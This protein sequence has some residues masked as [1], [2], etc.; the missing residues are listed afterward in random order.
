MTSEPSAT[1]ALQNSTSGGA[2]VHDGNS[3]G[4]LLPLRGPVW[5]ADVDM[6][7]DAAPSS[8][9]FFRVVDTKRLGD[10]HTI[11]C[12]GHKLSNTDLAIVP[13]RIVLSMIDGSHVV[14]VTPATRGCQTNSHDAGVGCSVAAATPEGSSTPVLILTDIEDASQHLGPQIDARQ[15]TS[16]FQVWHVSNAGVMY[17]IRDFAPESGDHESLSEVLAALLS[18]GAC[19]TLH[20]NRRQPFCIPAAQRSNHRM[21]RVFAAL[22]FAGYVTEI[23]SRSKGPASASHGPTSAYYLLTELGMQSLVLG[24]KLQK[25]K[26][27]MSIRPAVTLANMTALELALRAAELGWQW[28][29][30]PTSTAQR[31]NVRPYKVGDEQVW[32]THGLTINQPYLQCLMSAG[33]LQEQFSIACIPHG[34]RASIYEAMLQGKRQQLRAS[35]FA[36]VEDGECLQLAQDE[37]LNRKRKHKQTAAIRGLADKASMHGGTNDPTCLAPLADSDMTEAPGHDHIDSSGED[38]DA[39]ETQLGAMAAGSDF[40]GSAEVETG[41]AAADDVGDDDE[42]HDG[43]MLSVLTHPRRANLRRTQWGI[44]RVTPKHPGSAN[45]YGGWEATCP[46]HRRNDLTGCKKYIAVP[47]AAD[48][49]R[50]AALRAV[51]FWCSRAASFDRQWKHLGFHPTVSDAPP[52]PVLESLPERRLPRPAAPK[53]DAELDGALAPKAKARLKRPKLAAPSMAPA[54]SAQNPPAGSSSS[55][56]SNSSSRSSSSDPAASS[57]SSSSSS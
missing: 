30:L 56:G 14:D 10:I 23:H 29:R 55:S 11:S 13:H 18:T 19:E 22:V 2:L 47:S 20:E 40:A 45:K 52:W 44:F 16:S 42:H 46:Y 35:N 4:A 21:Q 53:T 41:G 49:A 39:V 48:G 34:Q 57:S 36:L 27:V 50:D 9:L 12:A 31:R 54:A 51:I 28:R 43:Q 25:P 15:L 7:D 24:H 5:T 32:F 37:S 8:R 6:Q 3:G 38:S 33:Q 17:T 26:D 1:A